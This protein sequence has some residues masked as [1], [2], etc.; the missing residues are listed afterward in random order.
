MSQDLKQEQA[1]F[2]KVLD[3]YEASFDLLAEKYDG[4]IIKLD[5]QGAITYLNKK[6]QSVFNWEESQVIKQSLR[7]LCCKQGIAYPLPQDLTVFTNGY[8]HEQGRCLYRCINGIE[9]FIHWHAHVRVD[10]CATVVG[11]TL[12]GDIDEP[13]TATSLIQQT[14]LN[15]IITHLPGYVFWKDKDS[16]FLGCN[17]NF[18]MSAGFEHENQ[19][20]GMSDE[21]LPWEADEVSK[22]LTDDHSVMTSGTPLLR[23]EETQTFGSTFKIV[24]NKYPLYN[25]DGDCIGLLGVLGYK[26]N[27]SQVY[28]FLNQVDERINNTLFNLGDK[29]KYLLRGEF[30]CVELSKREAECMFCLVK[31]YTAKEVAKELYISN[32]TV[33]THIN[34]VKGKLGVL[35]KSQLIQCLL[36]SNLLSEL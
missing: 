8:E 19:I 30:G 26:Q 13:H 6:A 5:M 7:I 28:H 10:K 14:S 1:R 31:G 17:Q 36:K 33:E 2:S 32:R 23:I 35:S 27:H 29:K 4:I 18:A 22:Y 3:N 11:V 34:N 21:E 9:I 20:V 16:R 15:Q 24:T 12:I 25:F